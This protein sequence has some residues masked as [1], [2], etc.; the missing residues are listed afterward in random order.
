MNSSQVVEDFLWVVNSPTLLKENTFFPSVIEKLAVNEIP[1]DLSNLN[2]FIESRNTVLLG[3]YFEALWEYYL[4]CLP[5]IETI[6][7]NKQVSVKGNTIGEIDYLIKLNQ[8]VYHL[9]VAGKFYLAYKNVAEWE[10]FIGPNCID[11]LGKKAAKSINE[12][13][14]LTQTGAGKE[15]LEKVGIDTDKVIPKF[16]LKGYIFYHINHFCNKDYIMPEYANPNHCRGWW[17]KYSEFMKS[18]AIL[19]DVWVL[20]ER[21]KWMPKVLV[22]EKSEILSQSMFLDAVNK[23]FESNSYPLLVAAVDPDNGFNEVSRGFITSNKWPHDN[24]FGK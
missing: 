17:C 18:A 22:N 4:R 7:A 13:L 8:T 9:E 5:Q 2:Q 10:N 24:F 3:K 23:Y 14:K 19:S 12:Q 11:N 16:L 20:P 15:L 21:K 6:F 1:Y